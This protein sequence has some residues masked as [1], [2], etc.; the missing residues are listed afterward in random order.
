MSRTV[1]AN[2]DHSEWH[3]NSAGVTFLGVVHRGFGVLYDGSLEDPSVPSKM[4]P[5]EAQEIGER[6]ASFADAV[7]LYAYDLIPDREALYSGS[8]EDFVQY[9]RDWQ[10]FLLHSNGY[11]HENDC[12]E[13]CK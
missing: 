6:F 3:N 9:M 8:R 13:S 4:T 7:F 10:D 1:Y 12:V 2:S 11:H 5:A